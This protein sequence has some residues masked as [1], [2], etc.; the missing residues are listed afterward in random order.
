[1]RARAIGSARTGSSVASR[2]Y[3]TAPALIRVATTEHACAERDSE[4][5]QAARPHTAL[6]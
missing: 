4:Q 6:V 2:A 5:K 1:V 3:R